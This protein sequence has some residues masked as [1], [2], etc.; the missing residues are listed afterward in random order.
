MELLPLDNFQ[1]EEHSIAVMNRMQFDN[2][3]NKEHSIAVMNRMQFG[4]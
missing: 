4:C 3:Q 1:N 2:F